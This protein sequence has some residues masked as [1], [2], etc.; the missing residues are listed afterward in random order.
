MAHTTMVQR[1]PTMWMKPK[2]LHG[3]Q[4]KRKTFQSPIKQASNIEHQSFP[5]IH[6]YLRTISENNPPTQVQVF[7]L[8]HHRKATQRRWVSTEEASVVPARVFPASIP[9][10]ATITAEYLLLP[11]IYNFPVVLDHKPILNP[12]CVSQ[13]SARNYLNHP[14]YEMKCVN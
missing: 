4:N 2:K 6:K 3:I 1:S 12:V 10:I 13:R 9:A 5:D 11:C 14:P 7:A 8:C